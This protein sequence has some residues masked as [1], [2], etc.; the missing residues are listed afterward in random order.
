MAADIPR[1]HCGRNPCMRHALRR[2]GGCWSNRPRSLSYF[3]VEYGLT[4]GRH[5]RRW[6]ST[7]RGMGS[8][9]A[10][11]TQCLEASHPPRPFKQTLH[12]TVLNDESRVATISRVASRALVGRK[13]T[14]RPTP[15]GSVG[16][17][18]GGVRRLKALLLSCLESFLRLLTHCDQ[19][20]GA[21][22]V[23][24][25]RVVEIRLRG[26]H[27]NCHGKSLQ[28]FVGTQPQ[29]VA[30]DDALLGSHANQFHVGVSFSRPQRVIHRRETAAVH[31]HR[32]AVLSARLRFSGTD[33]ADRRGGGK[34]QPGQVFGQTAPPTAAPQPNTPTPARRPHPT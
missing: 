23:Y 2:A 28:H 8:F 33:C 15:A 5:S 6:R 7:P 19:F 26:A 22:R 16:N 27:A 32:V 17:S 12:L 9:K 3:G 21:R 14:C 20:L 30:A 25:H 24:G 29:D 13:T 10:R 1:L 11:K 31:L 4:R 34:K 18:S